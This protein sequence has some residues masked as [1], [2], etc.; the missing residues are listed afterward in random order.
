[1]IKAARK[2]IGW[3]TAHRLKRD[4]NAVAMVEFAFAA[5]LLG[6]MGLVGLELAYTANMHMRVSQLTMQIADN[7]SRMGDNE[8]LTAKRVREGDIYDLLVGAEIQ[9]GGLDLFE[10]GRVIISSLEQNEDGGQWIH[11]QRCMGKKNFASA[12]GPAGTGE[13]GDSFPGMGMTGEKLMAP[14]DGAVMYVEVSLDYESLTKTQ[15]VEDYVLP[16]VISSEAAFT[17][18]SS[19]D[20][21]GVFEQDGIDAATCDK[22]EA[23]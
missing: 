13:T 1:M 8:V 7:A 19:R 5:P 16:L 6:F 20:L 12:Y 21:T 10:N 3:R 4:E 17:V 11:W 23:L 9:A 18:R 15:I 2:L 14:P 22:F